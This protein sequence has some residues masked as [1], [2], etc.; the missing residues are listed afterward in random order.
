MG[1]TR[2]PV[3]SLLFTD[4]DIGDRI[5]LERSH[6][7][8]VGLWSLLWPEVLPES[9]TSCLRLQ[10]LSPVLGHQGQAN[11]FA[12][13]LHQVVSWPHVPLSS[14]PKPCSKWFLEC[15]AK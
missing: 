6:E 7:S 4:G 1:S 10:R 9:S 12:F 11:D 3:P 15:W 13:D 5:G 2:G 14:S 8:K